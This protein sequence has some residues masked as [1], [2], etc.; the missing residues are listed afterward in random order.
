[1][2]KNTAVFMMIIVTIIW[3]GGFVATKLALD[4]GISAGLLNMLR[5]SIFALLTFAVFPRQVLGMSGEM[6]K[7]GLLIGI[8]NRGGFV[9]QA[10]GAMYTTPSNSAFL[11]TSNVVIVPI[12]AW[13][14]YKI[15]PTFKNII[16][17][18][19]CMFGMGVLTGIFHTEMVLNVGDVYTVVGAVIYAVS[20]VLLSKQPRN[21]HF[22]QSAFLMG[23]TMF[24]GGLICFILFDQVNFD[25][26]NI[27]GAIL[28]VL[29]LSV[30]SNFVANSLQI[31]SQRHIPPSTASL[32]MMLEGVFGSI[33]SIMWGFES[34]TINL[35]I[36]GSLI[37][38]SLILSEI[39]FKKKA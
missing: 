32:V 14:I 25:A 11:T 5:G 33:F 22:S 30:G 12:W 21:S 18:F 31:I 23:V 24:L 4:S 6:L 29:Y 1:M 3:G 9:L 10:I 17:I 27:S 35:L 39:D 36:G 26:I 19:V 13:V 20:I 34:F 7:A 37:L 38:T 15:R 28:P 2:K 8:F 16:A